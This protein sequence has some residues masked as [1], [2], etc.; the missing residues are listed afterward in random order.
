M[1]IKCQ[2]WKFLILFIINLA[3]TISAYKNLIIKLLN[4][5]ILVELIR[6]K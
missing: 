4:R 6:W 5:K 3:L 1:K 2:I